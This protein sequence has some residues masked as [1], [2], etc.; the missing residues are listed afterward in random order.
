[1]RVMTLLMWCCNADRRS[2]AIKKSPCATG[3][4]SQ[5]LSGPLILD[6]Y[7]YIYIYKLVRGDNVDRL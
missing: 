3:A 7:I 2:N 4:F 1:M 6:I 5:E